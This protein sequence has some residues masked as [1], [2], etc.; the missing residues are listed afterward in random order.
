MDL[1]EKFLKS[2]IVILTKNKGLNVK[3]INN[4]RRKLRESKSEYKVVKNTLL[5]RASDNTDV[6]K[7]KEHFK[8]TSAIALNF[9]DPV[10]PIKV[11]TQFASENEKIEVQ[12]GVMGGKVYDLQALKRLSSLPPREVLLSQLLSA[13]N[14]VPTGLVRALSDIPRRLLNVLSEISKQKES[15]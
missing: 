14:G 12:M 1:H 8:S 9:E 2:K 15:Q 4:L 11:L 10:A 5:A 3:A 6:A 13:M 7:I